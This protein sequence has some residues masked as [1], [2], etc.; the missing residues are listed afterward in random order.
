MSDQETEGQPRRVFHQDLAE[1]NPVPEVAD[2]P[3]SQEVEVEDNPQP[4]VRR[5]VGGRERGLDEIVQ[6]YEASTQEALRLKSQ[7]DAANGMLQSLIEQRQQQSP[8]VIAPDPYMT[9]LQEQG[10]NPAAIDSIVSRRVQEQLQAAFQPF[11]EAQKAATRVKAEIPEFDPNLLQ[12]RLLE[13]QGAL[14]SYNALLGTD[15]ELAMQTAW[16]LTQPRQAALPVGNPSQGDLNGA[17]AVQSTPRRAAPQVNPEQERAQ[18]LALAK[19][20]AEATGDWTA[21]YRERSRGTSIDRTAEIESLVPV[22][23]SRYIG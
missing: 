1:P 12:Q 8:A 20:H 13:D 7:L 11:V 4:E 19:E 5:V 6:G 2:E 16:K 14:K 18:K 17:R 21:Y 23:K 9:E 15:P 3:E 22:T 10:V